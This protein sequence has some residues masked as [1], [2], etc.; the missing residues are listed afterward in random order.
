MAHAEF[1]SPC[2]SPSVQFLP[3]TWRAVGGTGLPHQHS[4]AEQIRRAEI[5]KARAGLGQWPV[6]GRLW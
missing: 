1:T 6:C 3:S 2:R 5:L 4:K